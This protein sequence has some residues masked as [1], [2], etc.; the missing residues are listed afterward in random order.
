MQHHFYVGVGVAGI[1]GHHNANFKTEA[2]GLPTTHDRY[3]FDCARLG[4]DILIGY[5]FHYHNWYLGVETDYL[6]GDLHRTNYLNKGGDPGFP[7]FTKI[8][9]N[10]AW[11]AGIRL[12]Y[13]CQRT[14][15][16]IRVG[17]EDRRFK[18]RNINLASPAI[19]HASVPVSVVSSSKH[20]VAPTI[21]AGV[22]VNLTQSTRNTAVLGLEARY[23]WY[24]TIHRSGTN[25]IAG[26]NLTLRVKPR[27]ATALLT[28]KYVI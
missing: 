27:V 2:T 9:T 16:Y 13:T 8:N 6:L 10:G 19:D 7:L 24:S 18:I 1:I 20:R 21:G 25:A 14:T 12:G 17:M 22:D 28:L 3:Q 15:P 23:A 5:A 26:Y 11:G 4:G